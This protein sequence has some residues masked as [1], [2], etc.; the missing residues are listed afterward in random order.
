MHLSAEKFTV[1]CM[2]CVPPISCVQIDVLSNVDARNFLSTAEEQDTVVYLRVSTNR[3]SYDG[4][5]ALL[6]GLLLNDREVGEFSTPV[7]PPKGGR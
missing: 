3:F 4:L 2:Y 1:Q 6:D 7:M 5:T